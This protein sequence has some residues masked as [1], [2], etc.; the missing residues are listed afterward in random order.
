MIEIV[1]DIMLEIKGNSVA[2][3][4]IGCYRITLDLQYN[5]LR[6][7]DDVNRFSYTRSL[8]SLGL[9]SSSILTLFFSTSNSIVCF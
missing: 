2:T 3:D 9:S 6:Y 7:S 5:I 4:A 1:I 8:P